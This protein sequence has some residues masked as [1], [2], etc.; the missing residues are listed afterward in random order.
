ME[1]LW[2]PVVATRGNQR[3]IGSAPEPQGQAK[4]V[5][6]LCDWLPKGAQ[7]ELVCCK[8]DLLVPPLRSTVVAGDQPHPVQATEVAVDKRLARLRLVVR[9]LGEPEMPGGVL[10]PGVRL[11]ECVLLPCARLDVLPARTEHVPV[12]VADFGS[13]RSILS[14]GVG[15]GRAIGWVCKSEAA[16]WNPAG[17]ICRQGGSGVTAFAVGDRVFGFDDAGSGGHAQY[18]TVSRD[19]MVTMIPAG[20]S[21]EQAAASTEGAHYALRYVRALRVGDGTRVLVHGATGAIGTAAVQLL[22]HAGA[23]VVATSTTAN[24]E[25]VRTLGADVVVDWQRED[26]C[27]SGRAAVAGPG[28]ST[29]STATNPGA[30]V[31]ENPR[32]DI[33]RI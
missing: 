7:Q 20:L 19:R 11:Q 13:V 23:Y 33:A 16:G 18:K 8:L 2:S 30:A 12:G 24:V 15:W 1:R 25:L 10:V 22:K 27:T 14:V 21:Y 3:Q 9:A 17:S 31:S 29:T 28:R 32:R 4:T 26:F 5:A 6:L